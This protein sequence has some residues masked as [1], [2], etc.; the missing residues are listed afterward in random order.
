MR[1]QLPISS[2]PADSSLADAHGLRRLLVRR[3]AEPLGHIVFS[4]DN[5]YHF[6]QHRLDHGKLTAFD[7]E[8]N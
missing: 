2:N 1:P 3:D 4:S 6:G 8:A 5:G 7:T